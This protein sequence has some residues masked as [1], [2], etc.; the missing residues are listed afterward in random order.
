MS[1][2]KTNVTIVTIALFVATFISAMEGTIV[3][4]AMPTIVSDLRG[5][6]IMNWVFSIYLLTNA[7]A[8][9]IYGKLSDRIG[10]KP[11]FIFGLF[12]FVIGS[13]MSGLS[14]SMHELIIWR[15]IQGVGAG[16]IMPVS[17]TIIADIYPFEKRAKVMG[18]NGSAWGIASVIAPLL[19]G[20][21]VDQLTWHWVFFINVPIGLITIALIW[22]FLNEPKRVSDAKLDWLGIIWLTLSLLGLMYGVQLLSQGGQSLLQAGVSFV[23]FVVALSLFIRQEKRAADPIIFLEL[24]KNRVFVIQNIAAAFVSAYLI[25][26]NVYLPMW[27]Q[28]LLGLRASIAGFA[29]TPSSIL[30][31]VGS[32]IA[33]KL[34]A[35][36][37]PKKLL[38]VSL[39]LLIITGIVMILLP[40]TT[41]FWFFLCLSGVFGI[42]FG[43]SITG[44]TVTSQSLVSS[45][46]VGVTTSFNT[47]VRS[48]AQT[49]MIS[50]F[51]IV[52]NYSIA[53]G[54]TRYHNTGATEEMMNKVINPQTVHQLP[55]QLIPILRKIYYSG[56]HNIFILGFVFILLAFIINLMKQPKDQKKQAI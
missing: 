53:N 51:G 52:M 29:T 15:A 45:D 41:P 9:P 7:L 32:F 47:L 20:F 40:Q 5:V 43:I 33:G 4:T 39:G 3:S 50:V 10:R 18:W 27:T 46:I 49:I 13:A 54:M 12:V 48:L 38:T 23:V 14:H 55:H 34:L 2:K 44:T 35:S 25:A 8:T 17:F 6:A 30:W 28:G 31:V 19:G 42:G 16:T 24:F 21:I 26:F 36:A 11:V 1:K 37:T 22:F 56:L